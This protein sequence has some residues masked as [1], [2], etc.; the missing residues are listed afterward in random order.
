MQRRDQR[1]DLEQRV[2][3]SSRARKRELEVYD[4]RAIR[5]LKAHTRLGRALTEPTPAGGVLN[6]D[7]HVC[8]CVV[9]RAGE[10]RALVHARRAPPPSTSRH[11]HSRRVLHQVRHRL[12]SFGREAAVLES[13]GGVL[14]YGAGWL[15][16]R[17]EHADLPAVAGRS[18]REPLYS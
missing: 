4:V 18:T 8:A 14:S 15:R 5:D 3:A 16:A 11:A 10:Q 6:I 1:V 12:T 2:L 13:Q 7:A 9:A 17:L